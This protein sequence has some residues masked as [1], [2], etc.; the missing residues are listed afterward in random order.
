LPESDPEGWETASDTSDD[1][2]GEWITIDHDDEDEKKSTNQS[3]KAKL[4]PDQEPAIKD[5]LTPEERKARAA[6]LAA[7][8]V[9]GGVEGWAETQ[10]R[11]TSS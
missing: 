2:S 1:G 7:T 6:Q 8:R 10:R 4:E 5:T 11:S 9:S 3:K